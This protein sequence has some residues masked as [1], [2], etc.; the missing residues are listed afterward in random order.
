MNAPT[1][2]IVGDKKYTL[3]ERFNSYCAMEELVDESTGEVLIKA[4]RG[5]MRSLRAM[6]WALLQEHHAQE[7]PDLA[8]V[9][10]LVDE[11]GMAEMSAQVQKIAAGDTPNEPRK[12]RAR[13]GRA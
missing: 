1:Q 5:H 2:L 13:K 12:S 10:R 4:M 9:S 6:F 8:S 7:F 3:I 11:I